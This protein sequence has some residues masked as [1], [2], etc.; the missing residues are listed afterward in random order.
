MT[1]QNLAITRHV[2]D[3]DVAELGYGMVRTPLGTRPR[4]ECTGELLV[5]AGVDLALFGLN[6][7]QAEIAREI[8]AA[9]QLGWAERTVAMKALAKKAKKARQR[10]ARKPATTPKEAT[11]EPR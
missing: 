1:Q 3:A 5:L 8:I 4:R 6:A 10:A 9:S 2:D 7:E 11:D